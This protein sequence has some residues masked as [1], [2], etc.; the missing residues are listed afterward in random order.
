M[1]YFDSAASYPVLPEVLNCLTTSFESLYGNS[2]AI[3]S[4]GNEANEAINATRGDI[5]DLIG[6]YDS[7]IIFT[8]GATESNNIAFKSIL[9]GNPE[10]KEKR[11]IVTSSIEHKCVLVICAFFKTIGF[12][13]TYV[14]PNNDGIITKDAIDQSIRP[15]TALVSI[16]HVNNELGTINPIEEIGALCFSKSVLFHV[17]AAQSFLKLPI[18]VDDM[19]IDLL[20]ISA[21]KVGG[22][23]G[24]GAVYIRDLRKRH[25][26]PVIH[27]AGQEEG[28]RG[29]TVAA[30]LIRAFGVAVQQFPKYYGKLKKNN[31]KH[32][33][34]SKLIPTNVEYIINGQSE[35]TLLSICSI[36]LPQIDVS[37][38]IRATESRFCLAQGSACSSQE[39]EPSHVL[40]AIGLSNEHANKTL[41]LSFSH[42]NSTEEIDLFISDLLEI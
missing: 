38:L 29:G 40:T 22:P 35:S 9:L 2:T 26:E 17:D 34:I 42:F 3:H 13:I 8:S 5:A 37:L 21:H 33:F 25:L 23:K 1:I 16:M 12:E 30:P 24:I 15:D 7:E 14:K 11:H 32:Y 39:I 27:G 18:D 41:R 4:K 31:L 20:S 6:S 36:T 10:F 19:N 28:L